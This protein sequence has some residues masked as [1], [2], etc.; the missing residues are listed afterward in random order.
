FQHKVQIE[1]KDKFFFRAYATSEDA[2]NSYDAVLTGALMSDAHMTEGTYYRSYSQNYETFNEQLFMA[3]MPN[4]DSTEYAST[5]PDFIDFFDPETGT[6]PGFAEA[7]TAWRMMVQSDQ[8]QWAQDNAEFMQDYNEIV[9]R[10]TKGQGE[11]AFFEPGTARFDSLFNDVT[12]RLFTEGGSRFYDRSSL[13]HA[14]GEYIFDTRIGK[15]RMGGSGRLYRPNSRGTIFEDTLEYTRQTIVNE[16]G[17]TSVVRVDSSFREVT[18]W[19]AGAYVGLEKKFVD[20]RLT[21]QATLRIDKNENFDAVISPAASLVFQLNENT[22]LRAGVS[23]AVRNPTMADQFLYYDVGRAILLG[24]LSGQDSL[25]SLESFD[26]A[27]N[28][29]LF[30]WNQLDF[31]NVD[32]IEPEKART[33]EVGY[34]STISNK[35][36][37]DASYYYT[38]YE[39]F[40]GFNIGLTLPYTPQAERPDFT[41]LQVYRVAANARETVTTQGFSVGVNYYFYKTFA[42]TTNYSWNN[43]VSGEDDPIIPAF[44]TPEHKVNIGVNARDLKTDLGFMQLKNWGFSVNAKWVDGFIFEGSPQFTGFVPSYYMVDAAVMTNFKKINTTLKLGASNLTDNRVFTVY[45]GPFVGRMAYFSIVY[46]WMN[47]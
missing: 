25:V 32:P 16:D 44:N 28:S 31:F 47:R 24:N 23:S 11:N 39:D 43:L 27:R 1:K 18:N 34:R 46:E 19:Q 41:S 13:Y 10:T 12:S 40:I 21:L 35:I 7:N 3:G 8:L 9:E 29:A 26:E 2:G 45:G 37:V 20:E 4:P 6:A 36:Y 5:R 42:L 22:I 15:V 30:D 38:F 14:Q 17:T 33:F